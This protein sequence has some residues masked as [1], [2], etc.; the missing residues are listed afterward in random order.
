[1]TP[2]QM[3]HYLRARPITPITHEDVARWVGWEVYCYFGQCPRVL[4]VH[5][6]AFLAGRALG[7]REGEEMTKHLRT[8]PQAVRDRVWTPGLPTGELLRLWAARAALFAAEEHSRDNP[9]LHAPRDPA[10]LA[11]REVMA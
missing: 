10:E 1:M 11:A 9:L 3:F 4:T 6:L 7:F 5:D 8:L 2:Q